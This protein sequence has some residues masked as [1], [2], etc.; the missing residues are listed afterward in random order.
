MIGDG[1]MIEVT[2]TACD[3]IAYN[4]ESSI[5]NV[6]RMSDIKMYRGSIVGY[7]IYVHPAQIPTFKRMGSG[8]ASMTGDI[9]IDSP[10]SEG[11]LY[12]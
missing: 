2:F 12:L 5:H 11:R 6:I 7:T 10:C 1:L 8:F 9:E 3:I 4:P